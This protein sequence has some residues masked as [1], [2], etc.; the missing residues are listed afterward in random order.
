MLYS[1]YIGSVAPPCVSLKAMQL[2]R[3][4]ASIA[5][6][7]KELLEGEPY[8]KGFVFFS[9]T[10]SIS[11]SSPLYLQT[12]WY[13]Q[14]SQSTAGNETSLKDTSF[15][16]TSDKIVAVDYGKLLE[17]CMAVC[18]VFVTLTWCPSLLSLANTDRFLL[19]WYQCEYVPYHCSNF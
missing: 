4:G 18:N 13:L 3:M 14:T 2:P 16:N 9:L 7:S 17:R 8:E 1:K 5:R 19:G 15:F 6:F 12:P 11:S 10:L